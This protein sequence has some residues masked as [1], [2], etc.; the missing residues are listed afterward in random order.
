VKITIK[1][2]Y[3]TSY[4]E[5]NGEDESDQSHNSDIECKGEDKSDQSHN[6]YIHVECKVEDNKHWSDS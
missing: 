5:C 4:I 6:S 3:H 2:Q 1:D